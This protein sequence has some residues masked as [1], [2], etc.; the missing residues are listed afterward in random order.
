MVVSDKVSTEFINRAV[1]RI[2]DRMYTKYNLYKSG[3]VLLSSDDYDFRNQIRC[4][5]FIS[6]RIDSYEL[7]HDMKKALIYT[8]LLNKRVS[9]FLK[10]VSEMK[11]KVQ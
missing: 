4:I 5:D 3:L 10:S 8:A 1:F 11:I 2:S 9:K 7:S 6:G